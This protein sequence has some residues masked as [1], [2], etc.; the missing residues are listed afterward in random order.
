MGLVH[1]YLLV[2]RGAERTFAAIA[3]FWP[4]APVY[5]LL[6]DEEATQRRFVGHPVHTSP[7][8]RLPLRQ[9]RFRAL[10]PVLPVAVQHLP[11]AR[12]DIVISSSSAFAHGVSVSPA[13]TH[14][15]YCH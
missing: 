14:I 13:A 4:Q 6:Y 1:D 9:P 3:A 5:T 8:Q 12:H 7:I 15:S 2:M 11:T 10:L